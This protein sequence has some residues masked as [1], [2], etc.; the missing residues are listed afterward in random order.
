MTT[1]DKPPT[2]PEM[3]EIA[4]RHI[5]AVDEEIAKCQRARKDLNL[6]IRVLKEDRRAYE[7]HARGPR[8]RKAKAPE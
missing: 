5:S 6:R 1:N 3:R 2:I 8:R 4:K 7:H